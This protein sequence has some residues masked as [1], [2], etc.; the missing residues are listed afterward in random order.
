MEISDATGCLLDRFRGFQ[1]AVNGPHDTKWIEVEKM[2]VFELRI[3]TGIRI[4]SP[5]WLAPTEIPS[6]LGWR[7]VLI[8]ACLSSQS[9]QFYA[10]RCDTCGTSTIGLAHILLRIVMMAEWGTVVWWEAVNSWDYHLKMYEA[11]AQ[12]DR[13]RL[14]SILEYVQL[15]KTS[16]WR[17]FLSENLITIRSKPWLFL[18]WISLSLDLWI[19][20][21]MII[22]CEST[23][24]ANITYGC[25]VMPKGNDLPDGLF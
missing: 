19:S 4:E 13:P 3:S 17:L 9:N 20:L 14:N 16:F 11:Q 25:R 5:L 6:R 23:I 10:R 18:Q 24:S 21:M 7:C 1:I 8:E 22:Y 12:G 15:A 2:W